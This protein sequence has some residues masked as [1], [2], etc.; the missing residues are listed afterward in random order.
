MRKRVCFAVTIVQRPEEASLA[1]PL[2]FGPV[3]PNG[4]VFGP[5]SA[6]KS[7]QIGLIDHI[8]DAV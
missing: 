4:P 5:M 1:I 8:R 3:V 6:T 2:W 7:R